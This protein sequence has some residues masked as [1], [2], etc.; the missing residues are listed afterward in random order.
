MITKNLNQKE[1]C[2][3]FKFAVLLVFISTA[4]TQVFG[5]ISQNKLELNVSVNN[6]A[7]SVFQRAL[8]K[9]LSLKFYQDRVTARA[10]SDA[11]ST[12]DIKYESI[13][14]FSYAGPNKFALRNF[15]GN[16]L[17]SDGKTVTNHGV[18]SAKYTETPVSDISEEKNIA[19]SAAGLIKLFHP[20][21][22]ILIGRAK[23]VPDFLK[24]E[25]II[26]VKSEKFNDEMGKTVEMS[27]N[28]PF[29]GIK[30]PVPIK[31]WFSDKTGLIGRFFVDMT[32]A[33]R[34]ST[35]APITKNYIEIVF[36]DIVINAPV[37]NDEFTFQPRDID[38]KVN[39]FFPS[40]EPKPGV[41][42]G[43]AKF[44]IGKK[45][46]QAEAFD[47]DGNLIKLSDYQ[48]KIVVL[49][50]WATWCRGCNMMLQYIKQ[51]KKNFADQDDV[52]ILGVNIDDPEDDAKVRKYLKEKDLKFRN[53][54][55]GESR[56]SSIYRV[57]GTPTIAIIDKQGILRDIRSIGG[58]D[59]MVKKYS[60]LIAKLAEENPKRREIK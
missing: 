54:R 27:A 5:Q 58:S 13:Y 53:F 33:T 20:V 19:G 39:S 45:A 18:F 48:G 1:L 47:L 60:E 40:E 25:K 4:F 59:E 23:S 52:V 55:D 8:D 43:T 15:Y 17:I 41:D 37:K 3:F 42:D 11:L 56:I 31:I 57:I 50:F 10:E 22:N 6:K 7:Q 12:G 26:A 34:K 38:K 46:P 2:K 28:Y 29:G 21:A 49:E 14:E 51:V 36:G 30:E 24:I 44:L 32:E 35:N 16:S 9:Y